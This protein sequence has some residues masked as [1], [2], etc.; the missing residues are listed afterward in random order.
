MPPGV[1]LAAVG[2]AARRLRAARTGGTRWQQVEHAAEEQLLLRL[3]LRRQQG[4]VTPD[5][6]RGGGEAERP[7][8]P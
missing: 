8:A 6:A 1:V 3:T 4:G 5:P 7:A 2:R